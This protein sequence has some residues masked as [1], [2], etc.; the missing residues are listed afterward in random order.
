[1]EMA[2]IEFL[3][4]ARNGYLEQAKADPKHFAV[5]DA[6]QNLDSVISNALKVVERVIARHL[7]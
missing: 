3:H 2:D 6:S 4:K 1:M 5:I 7:S